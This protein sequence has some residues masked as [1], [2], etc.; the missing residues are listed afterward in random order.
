MAKTYGVLPSELFHLDPVDWSIC[1]ICFEAGLEFE[2]EA[3]EDMKAE[4]EGKVRIKGVRGESELERL[5]KK[6]VA[7]RK[8]NGR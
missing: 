5:E 2:K 6:K 3:R 1:N 7:R 4:A 8:Q